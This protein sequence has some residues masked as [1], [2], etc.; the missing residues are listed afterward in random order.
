MRL[1][2]LEADK[3][4]LLMVISIAFGVA[5]TGR[6]S[7]ITIQSLDPVSVHLRTEFVPKY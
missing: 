4:I 3:I 5:L 7:L 6:T 1:S 2:N